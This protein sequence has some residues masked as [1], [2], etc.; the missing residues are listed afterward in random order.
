M[1]Q[2][3]LLAAAL[4]GAAAHAQQA[5]PAAAGSA[6]PADA[7]ELTAAALDER[8]RGNLFTATLPDGIGWRV[9]YK[10]SG[11]V[12]VDVSNGA[13]D[14]GKWRTEDGKICTDYRGRF[15]SG[16]SEMRG[17]PSGTL[18]LKRNS[19]GEIVTFQ[20]Q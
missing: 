4:G 12:F 8:V 6:F 1:I 5:A 15:P 11:Y 20:K 13:R 18:Y 16:C 19:T 9:D 2:L 10:A 7:Q 17:G 3:L 14:S